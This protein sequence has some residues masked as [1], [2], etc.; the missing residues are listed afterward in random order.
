MATPSPQRKAIG[1]KPWL[2]G[3]SEVRLLASAL[4][5]EVNLHVV[6][7]FPASLLSFQ[8]HK[9]L[10]VTSQVLLLPQGFLAERSVTR[11]LFPQY[12]VALQT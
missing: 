11:I 12:G 4:Y 10:L 3:V 9:K 6:R 1:G 2:A 5:I 7:R 8:N